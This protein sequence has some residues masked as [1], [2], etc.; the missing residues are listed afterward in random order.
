MKIRKKLYRMNAI[1]TR[2]AVAVGAVASVVLL[3]SGYL[4]QSALRQYGYA[5]GDIGILLSLLY[6]D[7]TEIRD[8]FLLSD[9]EKL[10]VKMNEL[11]DNNR[12]MNGYLEQI[13]EALTGNEEE[14]FW[15]MKN[16]VEN[17]RISRYEVISLGLAN[18]NEAA[19]NLFQEQSASRLE[20]C[21]GLAGELMD[22]KIHRGNTISAALRIGG[23][24]MAVLFAAAVWLGVRS[25]GKMSRV[26]GSELSEALEQLTVAADMIARGEIS[27]QVTVRG[28]GEIRELAEAF[29]AMTGRLQTYIGDITHALKNIGEG[30]LRYASGA[31]YMGDFR[32]I[33]ST[34]Q[35]IVQ[36][37][38]ETMT[39]IRE[40]A[41]NVAAFSE[42]MSKAG[43]FLEVGTEKQHQEVEKL[44]GILKQSAEKVETNRRRTE[45]I[46]GNVTEVVEEIDRSKVKMQQL[47]DAVGEIS[48]ASGNIQKVIASIEE[49]AQQ[50]NLL[51]LNA[52]IE[53]A[54][55]GDA[56]K[57]FAVVALEIGSLAKQCIE[58]AKNTRQLIEDSNRAVSNGTEIAS[59]TNVVLQEMMKGLQ[60]IV[61]YIGFVSG[62]S[63]EQAEEMPQLLAAVEQIEEVVKDN[64]A[65]AM[66]NAASG[67]E[68]KKHSQRLKNMVDQFTI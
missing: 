12:Q 20:E 46:M 55:A 7:G 60:E 1:M 21:I 40:M 42:E 15:Q 49:I 39:V 33:D 19:L 57:G 26:I 16:A 54:R 50:T 13:E 58:A 37:L 11:V 45:S 63:N 25:A 51:S 29:W 8:I 59:E 2:V 10:D 28:E 34:M 18:Q 36:Q 4:Y 66:E 5:Q 68:L 22:R 35:G 24:G 6:R 53:A 23:I 14:I 65:T 61:S 32:E 62:F 38:G 64:S 48:S 44:T 3:V 31:D 30:N 56:G 47:V 67:E 9:T 52:S 43:T 17:Y 27:T 41:D